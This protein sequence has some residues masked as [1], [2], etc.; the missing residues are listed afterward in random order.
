MGWNSLVL[1]AKGYSE[2]ADEEDWAQE[3]SQDGEPLSRSQLLT[4]HLHASKHQHWQQ[5]GQHEWG[6]C[7]HRWRN[8]PGNSASPG[9]TQVCQ[10][11][12]NSNLKLLRS[13]LPTQSYDA[14]YLSLLFFCWNCVLNQPQEDF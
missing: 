8:M 7:V 13:L 11:I 2:G 12:R 9:K 5:T 4:E 10:F 1:K 14:S 6:P 3:T